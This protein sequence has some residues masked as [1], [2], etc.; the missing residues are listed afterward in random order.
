MVCQC[1]ISPSSQALASATVLLGAIAIFCLANFSCTSGD[2]S[3]LIVNRC[4][5]SSTGFGVAAGANKPFHAMVP[6][7]G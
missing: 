5:A 6:T 2:C 3:A 4:S 7:S 1:F